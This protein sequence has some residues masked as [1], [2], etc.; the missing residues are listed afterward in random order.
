MFETTFF[1]TS[2]KSFI[3]VTINEN[4]FEIPFWVKV[5]V[6]FAYFT[7]LFASGILIIFVI[8]ESQGFAAHHRLLTNC[9]LSWF[10][11]TVAFYSSICC[12]IEFIGIWFGSLPYRICQFNCWLMGGLTLVCIL[13]L[14]MISLT[15]FLYVCIWKRMKIMM[16]DLI[17]R[18]VVTWIF[19]FGLLVT[20]SAAISPG[21][22]PNNIL[23]CQGIKPLT[24]NQ[25]IPIIIAAVIFCAL[26]QLL[27]QIQIWFKQCQIDKEENPDQAIPKTLESLA[28]NIFLSILGLA[29]ARSMYVLNR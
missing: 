17:A 3:D 25:R 26:I 29:G 22:E 16:D 27:L 2:D 4:Y 14:V 15:R 7:S 18:I 20:I 9:F 28:L 23:I 21:L 6:T 24:D 10:Y 8:Y 12:G 13:F 19:L 5:L 11:S 1:E